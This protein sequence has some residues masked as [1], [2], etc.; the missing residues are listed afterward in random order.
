MKLPFD[1][2][3]IANR[4]EI[5]RRIM[6][7]CREL[8]VKTVAVHSDID[9]HAPFVRDA[10]EAVSLE[11]DTAAETYLVVEKILDAAKKTKAEAIHPGYGFLSEN[12]QFAEAVQTSGM[13]WIGPTP[14]SIQQM[15]SKAEARAL[16]EKAGVPLVPGM[17]EDGHSDEELLNQA[18]AIGFP[19]LI[20]ASA[21]GGGKGMRVV[22]AEAEFLG[23]LQA[24]R[25][26]AKSS[27][28]ND[29][30]IIEKYILNPRHIEVQVFGDTH[31]GAVHLFERECSIQ[32]RHQK[33][34]EESPSPVM[35]ESQREAITE[36]AVRLTKGVDYVNAG[37][38]E[39]IMDESGDFYFLEMN[40]RLQVEHPVTEGVTG[41]D[42]VALQLQVAAGYALPF[43]QHELTQRGHAIEVRVYAED[44][45]FQFA[46]QTGAIDV[47]NLANGPGIRWDNG[48]E[49]GSEVSPY[50]DPMLGKLIVYG[51]NRN[52]AIRRLRMALSDTALLGV[53]TNLTFLKEVIDHPAFISGDTTTGFIDKHFSDWKEAEPQDLDWLAMIAYE[54]WGKQ[55]TTAVGTSSEAQFDP[56][57]L[58]EPWRNV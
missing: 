7:T 6:H 54:A 22:E 20:K 24:T 2:L 48:I 40:T 9:Q 38:I 11:G 16:A 30:L 21:G 29:H 32:R 14:G 10:D 57:H 19:V 42:L 36:A 43:K 50:Y 46:P 53:Q 39:F 13:T 41:L 55:R 51:E 26:E 44:P 37:T 58:N 33:I 1:K 31:G 45:A 5:A 52:A 23:G 15:G 4:G 25:R 18:K 28:G 56:W 8:G 12:A 27:F 3:L 34:V 49:Q 17:A 35:N 47:L